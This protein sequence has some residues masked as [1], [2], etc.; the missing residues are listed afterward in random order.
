[1]LAARLYGPGDIRVVEEG[2]PQI[3]DGEILLKTK[4]AAICGSDLRMVANGYRG[5]SEE[6]PLTLGHEIAG[7]IVKVGAGVPYYQPGMRVSLAPNYGCGVCD[8]CVR[9]DTHLCPDY[10]A[11]GINI[12]GGFAEY[13]RIPEQPIRQG[14]ITLLAENISYE[15]AATFEPA[16]CVLNGQERCGV[17]TGDTVLIVG[18]GPIGLMHAMLAKASGAAKVLIRDLSAARMRQCAQKTPGVIPLAGG[19]L[20]AEVLAQTAGAGVDVCIVACPSPDMQKDSLSLMAM[21]GRILFF[22]GLPAGKDAVALH[23]NIIHYKQLAIYGSTRA[24]VRQYRKIVSLSAAGLLRLDAAV[25]DRFTI[26]NFAGA[27]K[28]AQAAQGLK[29]VIVFP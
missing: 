13:V 3:E 25:T 11:F 15:A 8:A 23:T 14:N 1:M 17:H 19:D 16:S 20:Q 6:H 29:C 5:V 27:V 26:E 22:G 10:Q 21:N 7:E 28:A 9:G 2:I 24:N 18:A 12:D 4:A